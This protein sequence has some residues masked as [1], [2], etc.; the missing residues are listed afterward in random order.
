MKEHPITLQ[1][2]EIRGIITLDLSQLKRVVRPQP[3]DGQPWPNENSCLTWDDILSDPVYYFACGHCPYGMPGDQ[4]WGRETWAL[5]GSAAGMKLSELNSVW[6]DSVV[7]RV[8]V[9][10]TVYYDWLSATSMPRWA[11]RIVLEITSIDVVLDG[12]WNWI[13]NFKPVRIN[14]KFYWKA[15]NG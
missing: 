14:N 4:L 7:Y 2:D 13:I 6:S 5:I 15:T 1:P 12:R 10:K 9:E 3:I 8:D 11:T